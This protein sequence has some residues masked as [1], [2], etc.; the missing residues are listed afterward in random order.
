MLQIRIANLFAKEI[1]GWKLR[2]PLPRQFVCAI[3]LPIRAG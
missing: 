2:E 1:A 3:D